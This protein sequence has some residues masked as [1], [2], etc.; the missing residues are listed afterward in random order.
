MKA[1]VI[2]PHYASDFSK[3]EA[4]FKKNLEYLAQCDESMDIIVL[5]EYSDAPALAKTREEK[6]I[7]HKK[8]IKPLLDACA[9]TARRCNAI[10]FVNALS[11]TETGYRNTTYAFDRT[12]TIV[13]K[14]YKTHIPIGELVCDIESD[15]T[16]DLLE[17]YVLEI[18]GIRFAFLTC[19]D[20]YFYEAFSV[21]AQKNVDVIIGC[22]HQR[23]DTHDALEI[24]SR[25]CA[26]NCN[27]YLLRSSISM[28]ENS[29]IC[30]AS[31]IVTPE[32]KVLANMRSRIGLATAEID[33]HK[34]YYKPAGFG[35]PPAAHYEY[36]EDGRNPWNY[37]LG[38]APIVRFDELMAYPRVCAQGG[39]TVTAPANS[40]PAFGSAISVGAEEISF[41]LQCTKDEELVCIQAETID[42]VSDGTGAVCDYT[43]EELLQFDFGVRFS[44]AYQGL[45]IPTFEEMLKKFAGRV[46]MNIQPK[47]KDAKILEKIVTLVNKYDCKKHVYI[48]AS[49]DI[50]QTMKEIAPDIS[51]C[52]LGGVGDIEL[53]VANGCKK[54]EFTDG[55]TKEAADLAHQNNLI[56]NVSGIRT[57]EEAYKFLAMGADTIM[58][59]NCI[60]ISQVLKQ[61]KK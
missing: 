12:G 15:Y 27:A 56:C 24:M 45:T 39:F 61:I 3:S 42:D 37:R 46:I 19:Y 40:M 49:A 36:I 14:Y 53:A 8:Y 57:Q 21:I 43:Y 35:N 58:T 4:C 54:V 16:R 44:N 60:A 47:V 33:P 22:S 31:M 52:L 11:E 25:F 38:G 30:G 59:G 23:S 55:F 51:R 7:S 48:T 2:Q 1:C 10:V 18:E 34:K 13:G 41:E 29:D 28:D 50:L 5:P 20:F 6:L 9:A 26:Y 32:G 17:P